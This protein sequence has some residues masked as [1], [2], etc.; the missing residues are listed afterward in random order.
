MRS[1]IH[2]L[3]ERK[4][5][6]LAQ[7]GAQREQ[8]RLHFREALRPIQMAGTFTKIATNPL[9]LL[10]LSALTVKLPWKRAFKVGRFV[11]KGVKM[12]RLVRRFL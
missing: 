10:G 12:F 6:L 4:G 5:R 7:A 2:L 3:E 9:V 11:F 1:S 8:V